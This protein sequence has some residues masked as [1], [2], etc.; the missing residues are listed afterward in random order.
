MLK[1]F[2]AGRSVEIRMAAGFLI[3]GFVGVTGVLAQAPMVDITPGPGTI[4]ITGGKLL[5]ITHGVIEN[6]LVLIEGGK[7]AAV[8]TAASGKGAK[9]ARLRESKGVAGYSRPISA[10]T[11]RGL[12]R[13]GLGR[14]HDAHA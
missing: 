6:G 8:G 10:G 13:C 7:I 4:A 3:L 11:R 9:G 12:C 2:F 14:R 5:T 1:D